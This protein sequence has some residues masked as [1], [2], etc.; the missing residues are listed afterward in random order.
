M[1]RFILG[2]LFVIFLSACS[3]TGFAAPTS[4]AIP[5]PTVTSSAPTFTPQPATTPGSTQDLTRLCFGDSLATFANYAAWTRVN[6][7]P[8]EGHS[9]YVYIYVNDLARDT[10]LTAS[11]KIFP[12]CATIVKAQLAGPDSTEVTELTVMV[13]MPAGYDPEND[14]WW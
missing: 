6:P 5:D 11:G 3:G 8:I 9:A 4:P 12:A 10:Y 1:R 14:D 13:K 2:V 7:K